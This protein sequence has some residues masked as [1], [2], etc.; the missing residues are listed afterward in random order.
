MIVD[1]LPS[2]P[3]LLVA[4]SLRWEDFAAKYLHKIDPSYHGDIAFAFGMAQTA[5]RKSPPR[6][7]GEPF[8]SHPIMTVTYL[9]EAGCT[10][11]PHW[12]AGFLHDVPEDEFLFLARAKRRIERG[13]EDEG[14]NYSIGRELYGQTIIAKHLGQ[15]VDGILKAITK[16]RILRPQTEEEKMRFEARYV[17]ALLDFPPSLPV[18]Q[19]DRLHNL[20]TLLGTQD[21]IKAKIDETEQVYMPAFE[22]SAHLYPQEGAVLLR[23]IKAEI[24]DLKK[25]VGN[26]LFSKIIID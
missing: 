21:E 19:A 25:R 5:H 2:V 14:W 11:P 9:A 17:V 24:M 4:P 20:R 26:T 15:E 23:D 13:Y 12:M 8:I 1:A 16:P 6:R 7:T 10:H 22:L 18:K 3:R